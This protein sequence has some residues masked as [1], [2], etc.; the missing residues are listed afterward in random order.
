MMKII[1]LEYIFHVLLKKKQLEIHHCSKIT[2]NFCYSFLFFDIFF[3]IGMC[4]YICA[5]TLTFIHI[6]PFKIF[7]LKIFFFNLIKKELN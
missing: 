2:I 5:H 6:N 7:F 3:N 1:K 4:V